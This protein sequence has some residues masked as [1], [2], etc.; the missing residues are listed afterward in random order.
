VDGTVLDSIAKATAAW[1]V[2][3]QDGTSKYASP[4]SR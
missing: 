4:G 1:W 3:Y 2:D